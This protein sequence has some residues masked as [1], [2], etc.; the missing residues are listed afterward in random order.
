MHSS[1]GRRITF[2]MPFIDFCFMVIIIFLALLSIAYFTP[3]G[4]P[5]RPT[6]GAVAVRPLESAPGREAASLKSRVQAGRSEIARLQEALS[7]AQ[8][9][10]QERANAGR[11]QAGRI[12]PAARPSERGRGPLPVAGQEGRAQPRPEANP[13]ERGVKPRPAGEDAAPLRAHIE[14]Q[15][16]IIA[17]LRRQAEALQAEIERLKAQLAQVGPGRHEYTDL[18]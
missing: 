17:G 7:R 1:G 16:V 5:Q 8:R 11:R 2:L 3:P 12:A 9:L 13:G 18:R 10:L 14:E 4:S 6:F 15:D